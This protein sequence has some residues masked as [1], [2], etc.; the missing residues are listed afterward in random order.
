MAH[1]KSYLSRSL[2]YIK[3]E[4]SAALKFDLGW[5]SDLPMFQF[6]S[7][8]ALQNFVVGSDA[9]IGGL[10]EAYWGLTPEKT[11]V[12]W[13]KLSTDI[14][15][16]SKLQR[17]G[18][19]G[20][21]SKERPLTL[22]HRPR[23]DTSA[24]RY[25][26][27]RAKGDNRQWFVNLQTDG[28]YPTYLWQHRLYFEKPGE[29]E[30]LLIPFRDFVLTSHGYVQPRQLAMDRSKV[31]TVG[32]SIVRQNGDFRLELDWIRAVNTYQ[33]FGDMDIPNPDY[34][35]KIP[36]VPF[37]EELGKGVPKVEGRTGGAA[38]RLREAAERLRKSSKE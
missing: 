31:K 16:G 11:G 21:K 19:A 35:R 9:D 12:M 20:V 8:E 7:V 15:E 24:F 28:L 38:V 4:A 22:F 33:T 25:L 27:V 17:S 1:M 10:S 3:S 23:F 18:Y 26:A 30:T 36:Q 14:P 5:K 13:G 29:W 32:F 2:Q 37:F 34:L 6:N